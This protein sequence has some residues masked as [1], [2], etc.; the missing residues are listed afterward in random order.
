MK[1]KFLLMTGAILAFCA[2][3][4][5]A[6]VDTKETPLA[7][8]YEKLKEAESIVN[9]VSDDSQ[10][11]KR[12]FSIEARYFSP[13]MD[14]NVKSDRIK[15]RDGSVGL[16][17]DLGFGNDKAP[18]IILRYKRFTMDYFRVH[19]TGDREFTKA[20]PLLFGGTNLRGNVHSENEFNYLKLQITNPIAAK[21]GSG[22][23][24][25]YGITGIYW[26]GTASGTA[27]STSSNIDGRTMKKSEDL[28]AAL[29]TLGIGA[30]A[31]LLPEV[32]AYAHISGIVAGSYG[33]FY[34]YELGVRYNPSE[35]IGVDIGYRKIHANVKH[36]NDKGNF[37]LKGLYAGVRFD[38]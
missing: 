26:K 24:W 10:K 3:V 32:T 4:S 8:D 34:D 20:N 1:K 35:A 38:F 31:Q 14:I 22:F 9:G 17:R 29:P 16:K 33:H 23:D 6:E 36:K 5:A 15:Y 25:S 37:T 13:H 28:A 18:E 12:N 30:H 7:V 19:G 2:T 11:K 27:V 21:W